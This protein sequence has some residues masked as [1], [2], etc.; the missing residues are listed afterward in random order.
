MTCLE[1]RAGH[2]AGLLVR[3]SQIITDCCGRLDRPTE[4]IQRPMDSLG[5]PPLPAVQARA[6]KATLILPV[7]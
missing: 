3:E 5:L 4:T 6:I 1:C 2:V 7:C